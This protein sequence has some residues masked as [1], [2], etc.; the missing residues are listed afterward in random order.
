MPKCTKCNTA[1]NIR[2]KC[3]SGSHSTTNYYSSSNNTTDDIAIGIA[4]GSLVDTSPCST[5]NDYCS[6]SSS[7]DWS[8]GGGD[9]GGG[10]ASGDW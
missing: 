9:T 7:S 2:C 1:Y 5:S 10:G 4:L 8:G 3:K 6:S